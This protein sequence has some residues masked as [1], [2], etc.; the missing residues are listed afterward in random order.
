MTTQEI[1]SDISYLKGKLSVRDAD[2][3]VKYNWYLQNYNGR[4]ASLRELYTYPNG[5]YGFNAAMIPDRAFPAINVARNIIKTIHSKLIQSK[6]RIYFNGVNSLFKTLKIIRQ[7][8]IYFDAFIDADQLTRKVSACLMDAL[9]FSYGI[10]WTDADSK[11]N[12]RVRPWEFYLDAAERN[13]G[14]YSRAYI[15]QEQYPLHNLKGKLKSGGAAEAKLKRDVHAKCI[16]V[17]YF[18][19]IGK[20]RILLVDGEEQSRDKIESDRL[21]FAMIYYDEPI[22]GIYGNSVMDNV[23]PVQQQINSILTRVHE[24]L[25]YSPSHTV[26]V[27]YSGNPNGT[28]GS[29]PASG[30][31][32]AE[33]TARVISNRVGN[34]VL[35]NNAN[36]TPV[37]ATPS[38]ISPEYLTHLQF[39]I[40]QA[41]E[42]EGVSQLSATGKKPSG[43]NS[44]VA[45][46]TLQDVES[47][48]FQ[49]L[50][51][52]LIQFYKDIYNNMI[53]VFPATDDILPTRL[54]RAKTKWSDI[55]KSRE[56]FSLETSLASVLSKDPQKKAEQIEKLQAQGVIDP[57]TAT[58][59][60]DIPDL[61]RA[62]S[63]ASA[64]ADY[65]W[66]VIE[67]A[68]EHGDLE[69]YNVLN[70][71]QCL[72]MAVNTLCQLAAADEKQEPINNLLALIGK[73]SAA[74]NESQSIQNPPMDPAAPPEPPPE[75]SALN[76][77]QVTALVA[78]LSGISEGRYSA[79]TARGMVL[80]SYPDVPV[81]LV[82]RLFAG[83]N[84]PP[85]PPVQAQP[86]PNQPP[87]G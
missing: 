31:A 33:H 78:I 70:L 63:T 5:Y 57:A 69:Y 68:V 60:L 27:P 26:Y 66:R 67:D 80:I 59:L 82:E 85:L 52:G 86:G 54:N 22:K 58:T 39:F 50:L 29:G 75:D 3:W 83:Y 10:M 37:V 42:M 36:G 51:D 1:Q 12:E 84:L 20:E 30:K 6:G 40:Q 32:D 61:N 41:F 79:D 45:L 8:Q 47:E 43:V 35:V 23:L 53:D 49:A 28:P 34:V 15:A 74:I 65:C 56:S 81:P 14:S 71:G 21:P 44:G 11:S 2:Y 7:A 17:V 62:Y 16:R 73:L 18:D 19:L 64:S 72:S 25:R 48:R 76:G 9:I 24:A 4:Q 38:P 13:Y 55:K 87:V 77:T 46:D